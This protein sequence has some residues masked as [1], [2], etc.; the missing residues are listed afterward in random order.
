MQ[1]IDGLEPAAA[2]R[3]APTVTEDNRF[4]WEAAAQG[5]LVAQRCQGCHRL[6]HPPRPMC[7]NCHGL[8]YDEV[9][10]SG[11]G[12]VYSYAILHH[13]QNPK[14]AYPLLAALVELDEGIR[15]VTNIVGVEP[16]DLRIGMPVRVTFEA[17]VGDTSVPVFERCDSDS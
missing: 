11:R 12:R 15:L 16:G 2:I 3:P 7:P 10:L 8:E 4:F 14:F 6:H 1:Q 17:T 5:R 13:P 9:E